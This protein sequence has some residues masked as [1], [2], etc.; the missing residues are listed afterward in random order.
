MADKKYVAVDGSFT[1]SCDA[2][3]DKDA[4]IVWKFTVTGGTE[5]TLTGQAGSYDTG[6]YKISSTYKKTDSAALTDDG[7]YTC[8][9]SQVASLT[10]TLALDVYGK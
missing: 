8:E 4:T 1:L 6:T 3:G 2:Y 10:D 9:H 7:S 5:T